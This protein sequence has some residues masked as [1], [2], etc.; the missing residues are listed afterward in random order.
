MNTSWRATLSV[1]GGAMDGL[2]VVLGCSPVLIGRKYD[3]DIVIGDTS[4]SRRHALV[5]D[6][7]EGYTLLDLGSSNGTFLNDRDIG[8]H[9]CLLSDGDVIRLADSDTKVVVRF[10]CQGFPEA[11][12]SRRSFHAS[13]PDQWTYP[14]FP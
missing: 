14:T 7:L 3:N 2:E 11:L 12:V 6:S 9:E 13:K 4:V 8:D 1:H 10:Q 5:I